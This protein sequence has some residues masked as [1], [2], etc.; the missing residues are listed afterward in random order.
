QPAE[1]GQEDAAVA[2]IKLDLFRV[3]VA[4]AV[5]QALPL[6]AREVCPLGKAIGVGAFQVL[7]RLLQRMHWRIL[8][9]R[10]FSPV[11]PCGEFLAQTGIAELSLAL[12]VTRLLQR[13][14]LVE[15]EPARASETA[16]LALLLAV[17]PKFVFE[18]LEAL[19][20]RNYTLGL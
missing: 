4:E 3:G 13:Q 17:G 6:E 20:G 7:E 8:E 16:H 1:L 10:R 2:L 12:F 5:G 11:A 19:H 15:H 14:R 18:G 9:P